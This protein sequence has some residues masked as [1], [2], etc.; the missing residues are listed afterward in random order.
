MLYIYKMN[1]RSLS[2][3]YYYCNSRQARKAGTGGEEEK[4]CLSIGSLPTQGGCTKIKAQKENTR[5]KF[6][7]MSYADRFN[8]NIVVI[9]IVF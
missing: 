7:L 8:K 6:T 4:V 3:H 2:G 9:N 5:P 1:I